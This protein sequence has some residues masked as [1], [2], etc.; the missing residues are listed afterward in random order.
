MTT[1][2]SVK[3]AL[4]ALLVLLLF[5]STTLGQATR[6]SLAGLIS[7]Q[8]GASVSG[9]KVTAKQVATGEEFQGTT[10]AQGAF[11]FPSVPLGQYAVT[12]EA[13]GFKR[14]ELQEVFVQVG[15]PAN[16]KAFLEIGQVSE[17]VVITGE[18]QAV[19]NT[20]DATLTNVIS[21]RQ[22]RD[23]P[24]PG[25]NPLDL[26]RL[27]AGIAVTGDD[28]RNASVG[29]L[30]GSATNV[31]QDGINAMDNFVKTSSFFAIS[32]PSLN[33]T[34]EFSVSVGT[35]GPDAGRGVAQVRMVTKSGTNEFHGGIF[36][37]HRN[38]ALNANTFFNNSVG[39]PRQIQRQN[40]FG[41]AIG[42][43]LWFPK[44]A[45]GPVAYD[46]RDKS[47]WFFSYEGF[48]EPFS[49][50]RNRTVLTEEARRG[51]YRY[52]GANGQL[53]SLN[54]LQIGNFTTANPLTTA[55]LNAMPLPN[56]TLVGDGLNTAGYRFNASGSSPNDKYVGRFDQQLLENSRIGS[57]KLEFVVNH[58]TF[59]LKPDTF[60]SLDAPFPGG[61]NAFQSSKRIL[62]AG[63]IHS[64][65]GS[66]MTNEV[67]VGHQRA[68]VGFLRDSQPTA[69]FIGLPG[70]TTFD[71]TFMSQGRNT[72]VYQYIDNFSLISGAHTFRFGGDVQSI[73]AITFNDAGINQTINI[74]TNAANPDGILNAEFPNLPA[75][76]T[77]VGIADRGRTVYRLLSGLLGNS[78]ATFNVSSPTSGFVRGATRQRDFKQRMTS[79]YFQDQWRVR[80]NFT[81]NYGVRHEF[82]G[83]PYEVNGLAIQ[84][85]GGLD[86]LFGISGRNNLFNPGSRQG[87]A[88]T[89]IDFVNGKTGKK[90][91]NNDWNNFAPSIGI[92]YSPNFERGPMRWLFGAEGK[93]SIRTG[94]SIS[95]LQDGFT[96]VSNALGVGTTNPGLVQTAANNV[97]TGVLT[98]A[99]VS[100]T[101]PT[102]AIPTTDAANFAINN[103]N[104][105]WT[106]DPNLRTPYVQ[107]WSF[108]IEREIAPNTAFE[109]RYVGNHAVKIFRAINYN[110]VN[111]FENGFLN[112]FLNAQKNLALNGGSSFAPGA[113]GTV[114]L[115]IFA[116]LF[117]GLTTANGY[118]NATLINNLTNNNVGTMAFTLANS[119]VYANNRRNLTFNGQ[120]SPN[121]FLA[122]P[123]AS[124]T[125]A[126]TNGS[127]SNYN[128][129][130]AEIRRRLSKG[131]MLQAN[132]TFSKAIT[133]SEG[134]QS[135]LE[136]YRTLRN[137]KLDRHRANFDQTHRF[138]G[139]FI[140]EL[141]FGV[142][143]RWL[144]GGNPVIRKAA[145]GWQLG[146]I[147]NW[148][149]GPPLG[150][151]SGRT[152][153]NQFNAGLNPAQ[154]AGT[155]FDEFRQ[156]TG[157][158]KTASGVFFVNPSLLNVTTN[159]TGQ[160]TGAT[161]KP[162]L[163]E[164]PTPG[165]FGNFPRN[166][167]TGP[168]F[169]QWDFSLTKRTRFY[170]RGDVE[171]KVTFYNAFNQ[172]NFVFGDIGAFDS[173]NF[174]RISGQRGSPRVIH[175]ILG[176][177]F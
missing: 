8:S 145:E 169:T 25:R 79:L 132:Y 54:I 34:S 64:T 148:Q 86:G 74:G 146:G 89:P 114:A 110:E 168:S 121:F 136:S 162:G 147:V 10:D 17:A 70:V 75:G 77:G 103:N 144:N 116:T 57:H 62:M 163:L 43:P 51:L 92:A 19:V 82:Q 7:D 33:S 4:T 80:R 21:T 12:I 173:A 137:I 154:L 152:T 128:S 120:P 28:T 46:G 161:L 29:G 153:F 150:V 126:L 60:N 39:T 66:R 72:L 117:T 76:A 52:T 55:L 119:P 36:W 16:V 115:P 123:N 23:L 58:A 101:T 106:F 61:V 87:Q 112:E 13:A 3:S 32:A 22:V 175:F 71:N 122:N 20:T 167:I 84:P 111:I 104:G 138:I 95:Y 56:N 2:H 41:G 50:T 42:G 99:G 6:S 44:K 166:A 156:N 30:R 78:N 155:S 105:L 133:D 69:P 73:T 26:A 15:T 65:F 59:L 142:G 1:N 171:F 158:F 27:Q 93:S 174:G 96:V 63:A 125:Q 11:I 91:Y 107:Q 140:Y 88:T 177:N 151:F 85:V 37:Q 164:A 24:L 48:R 45:F 102:F 170:E 40:F 176:I 100:L 141:P 90:L 98:A 172:A 129:L 134:S 68:P 109:V 47:F 159:T 157:I 127:F 149:S 124:F 53:E 108:G 9:A 97:P 139:N 31:T 160:A 113:A 83:V 131:L 143:R 67:R 130:Q 18:S 49:V 5:G 94:F 118:G 81:L 14:L 35:I 135:T 165:T 38:D